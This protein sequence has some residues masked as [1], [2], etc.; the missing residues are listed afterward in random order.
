MPEPLGPQ[1]PNDPERRAIRAELQTLSGRAR[2]AGMLQ[3]ALVLDLAI[4]VGADD[5]RPALRPVDS[6]S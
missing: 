3:I 1:A 2:S 5:D 6:D 4:A